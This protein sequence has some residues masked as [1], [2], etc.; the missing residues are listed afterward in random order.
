MS[1]PTSFDS[2]NAYIQNVTDQANEQLEANRGSRAVPALL[3][4]IAPAL[5]NAAAMG[6]MA[7]AAYALMPPIGEGEAQAR[8]MRL[9]IKS[10]YWGLLRLIVGTLETTFVIPP[11]LNLDGQFN[12]VLYNQ[13]ESRSARIVAEYTGYPINDDGETVDKAAGVTRLY[14]LATKVDAYV[15][16]DHTNPLPSVLISANRSDIND[17]GNG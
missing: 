1:N 14:E 7:A 5:I 4:I 13:N 17:W 16:I 3:P 6:G 8:M 12:V 10:N 11:S 2:L 9:G 15:K